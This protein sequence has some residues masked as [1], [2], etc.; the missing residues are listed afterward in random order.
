LKRVYTGMESRGVIINMLNL[1]K[2]LFSE[3]KFRFDTQRSMDAR[4]AK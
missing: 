3:F 1:G 4:I 2:D